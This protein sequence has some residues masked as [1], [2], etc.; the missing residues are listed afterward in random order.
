MKRG[1]VLKYYVVITSHRYDVIRKRV[2]Y[3]E[4]FE[5]ASENY[6]AKIITGHSDATEF[7]F[8]VTDNK[9][10]NRA[11][12]YIY[13]L[14]VINLEQIIPNKNVDQS[15]T[16]DNSLDILRDQPDYIDQFMHKIR[17]VLKTVLDD[18]YKSGYE[19]GYKD[20]SLL[21]D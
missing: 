7:I 4:R 10:I 17:D 6:R 19:A 3:P 8:T 20:G 16:V 14:P 1:N 5:E 2:A 15:E 18:V 21:S 13:E 9:N 12:F 11:K